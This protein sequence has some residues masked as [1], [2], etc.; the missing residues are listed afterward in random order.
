MKKRLNVFILLMCFIIL[1]L[2]VFGHVKVQAATIIASGSCGVDSDPDS[3]TWTLDSEGTLEFFGTGYMKYYRTPS[4]ASVHW[5]DKLVPWADHISEI[6]KVII[7]E[8]I[9]EIGR[10]A[11]SEHTNL[12]DVSIASSVTRIEDYAFEYCSS[13]KTVILPKKLVTLGS[14]AFKYC[15]GLETMTIPSSIRYIDEGLFYGCKKMTSVSISNLVDTI[16]AKA[17]V[18]CQSLKSLTLPSSLKYINES[19]FY[20]CSS[21][22]S[23]TI[24]SGVKKIPES[25]F[26][27]CTALTSVSIPDTV[28]EIEQRA[29]E[30]CTSLENITLPSSLQVIGHQAFYNCS[31]ITEISIPS[32]VTTIGSVAFVG[33]GIHGNIVIPDNVTSIGSKAFMNL[34]SITSVKLPKQLQTI[35][36]AMF[37]GCSDLKSV[38]IPDSVT[39]IGQSA[40][41]LCSSLE[42]IQLPSQLTSIGAAAFS[43][44]SLKKIIIPNTVTEIGTQAFSECPLKSIVIPDSVTSLG[45]YPFMNCQSLESVKLSENLTTLQDKAFY[46]CSSL[47]S[48]QIPESVISIG[49]Y[50]FAL[51]ESLVEIHLPNSLQVIDGAAFSGCES[52]QRITIPPSVTTI[53]GGTFSGCSRLSRVLLLGGPGEVTYYSAFLDVAATIYYPEGKPWSMPE[54]PD[55]KVDRIHLTW[56]PCSY[57][58][59]EYKLSASDPALYTE[60]AINGDRLK[61]ISSS[62]TKSGYTFLGW[63]RTE[64]ATEATYRA[65]MTF[66]VSRD[67]TFYP[68]WKKTEP[69]AE[70]TNVKAVPAGKG[71]VTLTWTA[72]DGAEGYLIY[73]QKNGKYAY[74]GMTTQGTTYT[75]TKAL[76]D[77]YNYYWVFPYVKDSAGN[78][79]PHNTETYVYAKGILTAVTGLKASSVKGGVKLTWNAVTGAEGYLVYGIVAGKPYGYVGMTTKG[80]TFTDKTA[81]STE[82]N[83]YWVFPYFKDSNGKM[84]VGQTAKYT[85]GRALK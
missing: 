51:C 35:E 78:M 6:K 15:T 77:D 74:V 64:D 16:R 25:A 57:F 83:Y 79:V 30:G 22:K 52:L 2:L 1:P 39:S 20:D 46:G 7:H 53:E 65:G 11:F 62:P 32:N 5:P 48:I 37:Y 19:A 75:D 82:Y 50:A 60:C 14:Y 69:P 18:S 85:Y 58:T 54:I 4:L 49:K 9:I 38:Y 70:V 33:T 66:T 23:I 17:F 12:A 8:G 73:G 3:I 80:T 67:L 40:F 29:F 72:S 24:P 56:I 28:T 68:V 26:G 59:V 31:S 44:S 63:A 21:I 76:Y 84:I 13:L 61:V 34:K 43:D 55:D 41:A 81:S 71:K 45:Q 47:K 10:F 42:D 36:Y 27:H